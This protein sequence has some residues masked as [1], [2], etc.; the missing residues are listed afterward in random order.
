[1]G[2]WSG[3]MRAAETYTGMFGYSLRLDG[4]ESR[5]NG[6][7]RSRAIVVHPWEGSVDGY[8]NYWGE[9]AETW[10]CPGIDPAVSADVINFL[11]NGGLMFFHY[12]DG[13][14]LEALLGAAT[15]PLASRFPFALRDLWERRPDGLALDVGAACG[16]MTFELARDHRWAVGLDLA[17]HWFSFWYCRLISATPVDEAPPPSCFDEE[18]LCTDSCFFCGC[19]CAWLVILYGISCW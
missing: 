16:R 4:L 19:G 9:T 13:D 7:V 18:T 11:A 17:K 12:P 2:D 10:G 8:V 6:L 15:P 1:M 3:M 14:P 5:Y